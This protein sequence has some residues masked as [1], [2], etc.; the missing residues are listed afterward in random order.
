VGI[1]KSEEEQFFL[2][3]SGFLLLT[4]EFKFLLFCALVVTI[5]LKGQGLHHVKREGSELY[6][7]RT[8]KRL[9]IQDTKSIPKVALVPRTSLVR[10]DEGISPYNSFGVSLCPSGGLLI[11]I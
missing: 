10:A 1:W 9:T 4:P 11:R 6:L 7:F 5:P 2:V 8:P 3:Y